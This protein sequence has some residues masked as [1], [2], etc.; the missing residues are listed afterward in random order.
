MHGSCSDN[1][2]NVKFFYCVAVIDDGIN[3]KLFHIS[4]LKYNL[5]IT[6]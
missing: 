1:I 3:E 4:D 6:P 5:E 2:V